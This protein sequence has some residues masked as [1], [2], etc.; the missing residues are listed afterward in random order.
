MISLSPVC[1]WNEDS[2]Y[3]F[4]QS[5]FFPPAFS[6]R[7]SSKMSLE[8]GRATLRFLKLVQL[9]IFLG[10]CKT[11]PFFPKGFSR[12]LGSKH[13]TLSHTL[14][15]ISIFKFLV[16]LRFLILP[17]ISRRDLFRRSFLETSVRWNLVF[18]D[19]GELGL[20]EA[21]YDFFGWSQ[22]IQ[23]LFEVDDSSF[24]LENFLSS[25][26]IFFR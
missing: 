2:L 3:K 9:L 19:L 18:K 20:K 24:P 11:N 1:L 10:N 6:F 13:I 26:K 17:N 16:L 5:T 7:L 23:V 22:P 21:P 15:R 14:P 4:P 12:P 25:L 8:G